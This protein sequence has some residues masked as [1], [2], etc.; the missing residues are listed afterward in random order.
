MSPAST[1]VAVRSRSITDAGRRR[2]RDAS[3]VHLRG[4]SEH[5]GAVLDDD[6]VAALRRAMDKILA[7]NAP[8][9]EA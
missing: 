7:A 4:V 3:G 6:D 1:T 9:S 8:D 2:L 5:F